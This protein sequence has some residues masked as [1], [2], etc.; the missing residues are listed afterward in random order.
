M[1]PKDFIIA[2]DCRML[3]KSGIGTYLEGVLPYFVK[4]FKCLLIGNKEKL[5]KYKAENV[6]ICECNVEVFSK[7]EFFFFPKEILKKINQAG[8]YYSPYCNIP[9]GI[10][11]PVFS[12]IHDVVFLDVKNLSSRIGVFARRLIYQRAINL[13]KGI[14]TVSEFSKNRILCNLNCKKELFVTYNGVPQYIESSPESHTKKD[15]SILFVGNIKKHK[16]LSILLN[17]YKMFLKEYKGTYIPKLR[18]VGNAENFRTKDNSLS[19]L[20]KDF[21]STELE[22]TGKIDNSTLLEYYQ[23]ANLLIQPS[24]YEGF[25]IPPLE[26][27]YCGTNALISDIDVFKEIYKNLPVSFFKNANPESLK[28]EMLLS[29]EK[30]APLRRDIKGIYSYEKTAQIITNAMLTLVR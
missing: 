13:S 29:Y 30:E 20:L 7:N 3:G 22:F 10:K 4:D 23:K 16:G 28:D 25:G 26:A 8:V 2:A 24:L 18:I 9:R 27:L 21:S 14:F 5:L 1:A 17:A 15:G 6:E 12:T 11:I 19:P